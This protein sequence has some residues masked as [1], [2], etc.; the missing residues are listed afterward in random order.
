MNA[1]TN[2]PTNAVILNYLKSHSPKDRQ[3]ALDRIAK[4]PNG[5]RDFLDRV[6][7]IA[8]TTR[9]RATWEAAKE[10]LWALDIETYVEVERT[11]LWGSLRNQKPL[12]IHPEDCMVVHGD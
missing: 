5:R 9:C 7:H 1:I 4:M 3:F 2:I 6:K 10:C 11:S 12:T 8:L